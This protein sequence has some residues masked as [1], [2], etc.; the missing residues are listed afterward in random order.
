MQNVYTIVFRPRYI[1][2]TY[3]LS[4]L[5]SAL[6]I[7]PFSG[8]SQ[9]CIYSAVGNSRIL[10]LASSRQHYNKNK[11]ILFAKQRCSLPFHSVNCQLTND[12]CQR[13][14]RARTI[15]RPY[16]LTTDNCQLTTVKLRSRLIAAANS[17]RRNIAK[18][19]SGKEDKISIPCA[20]ISA[21]TKSIISD[22]VRLPSMYSCLA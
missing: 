14:V 18:S 3:S 11:K 12:N 15:H 17:K 7:I 16:Q 4:P 2:I 13:R 21:I 6:F 19:P 20:S 5:H 9:F 1:Y 22:K 8:A 10:Q